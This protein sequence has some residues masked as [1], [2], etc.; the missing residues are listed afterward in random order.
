[1]TAMGDHDDRLDRLERAVSDLATIGIKTAATVDR[2][3]TTVE[4]LAG[5]VEGIGA[6]LDRLALIV[7][8]HIENHRNDQ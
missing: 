4:G 7:T 1:M 2:L 8:D 6:H 3:A 5:T